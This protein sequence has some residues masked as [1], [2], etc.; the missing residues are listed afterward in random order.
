MSGMENKIKI[1][2]DYGRGTGEVRAILCEVDIFRSF[3]ALSTQPVAC[4]VKWDL[5]ARSLKKKKRRGGGW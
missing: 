1:K 2:K 4:V 5:H 3:R